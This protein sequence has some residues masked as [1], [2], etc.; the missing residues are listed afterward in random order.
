MSVPPFRP[1]DALSEG[2]SP[3]EP[4]DFELDGLDEPRPAREGLPPGYRMRHEPHYV[5]ALLS[6][7]RPVPPRESPAVL[8]AAGREIAAA[9]EGVARSAADLTLAGR[10]L[11]ERLSVELIKAEGRRASALCDALTVMMIEPTLALRPVDLGASVRAVV[12]AASFAMRLSGTEPR[13]HVAAGVTV[14]ADERWLRALLDAVLLAMNALVGSG[15]PWS[16]LDV[17]VP[18]ASEAAP[19]CVEVVQRTLALPQLA[20]L[21]FFDS[22]WSEHPAGTAGALALGAAH[23]LAAL[24]SGHLTVAAVEGGGCRVTLSLPT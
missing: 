8:A 1:H 24:H 15:A 3:E 5:D 2:T 10:S 19:R 12:E 17:S 7:P 16:T 23:R 13:V 9:L 18:S 6:G 21:R 14:R 20:I 22:G 4:S 11:R